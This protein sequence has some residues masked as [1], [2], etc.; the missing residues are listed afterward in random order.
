MELSLPQNHKIN[1]LVALAKYFYGLHNYEELLKKHW[2]LIYQHPASELDPLIF[3]KHKNFVCISFNEKLLE[4]DTDLVLMII[5]N[6]ISYASYIPEKKFN[7]I[8]GS[9]PSTLSSVQSGFILVA[10]Y[11]TGAE[12]AILVFIVHSNQ[13]PSFGHSS[14]I[15]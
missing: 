1:N 11:P 13:L 7:F 2:S 10:S 8:L 4:L 6:A 14:P 12:G 15:L 9:L 3:C 5:F